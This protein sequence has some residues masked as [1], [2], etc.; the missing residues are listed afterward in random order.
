MVVS[1][2]QHLVEMALRVTALPPQ[3][4]EP[5]IAWVGDGSVGWVMVEG[6]SRREIE[7]VSPT[8]GRRA[9]CVALTIEGLVPR[10]DSGIAV[11]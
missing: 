6:K 8:S 7:E 10:I 4:E 2:P 9:G 5:R 1:G 11:G 3:R